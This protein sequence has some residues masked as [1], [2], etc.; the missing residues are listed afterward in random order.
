MDLIKF[1]FDNIGDEEYHYRFYDAIE[2]LNKNEYYSFE[3]NDV[4]DAIIKFK[5]LCQP[6]VNYT[7]TNLICQFYLV[8]YYLHKNRYFIKEFP[9]ILSNPPESL[10]EFA[11]TDIRKRLSSQGKSDNGI[12][13]YK[14]RRDFVANLNFESKSNFIDVP[15]SINEMFIEISTRGS[16]FNDMSVDEKL[17][18]IDNLIE[19]MLKKGD[20]FISLDYSS[21]CFNY[22]DDGIVKKY[23]KKL[24]CFRHAS[25]DSIK[26]RSSFSVEQKNFLIDFGITIIKA[27][28]VLKNQM[29]NL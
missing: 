21:V 8:T 24:Q 17:K 10:E 19:H 9:K 25:E 28:Y 15:D 29:N 4:K 22:L 7:D 3:I 1:Y 23:R 20:K 2:N 11:Y 26:E 12:V 13:R 16:S 5:E 27:I 6:D 14:V 18:E